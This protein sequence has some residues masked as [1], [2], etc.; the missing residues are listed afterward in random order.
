MSINY[1]INDVNSGKSS[2]YTSNKF[3]TAAQEKEAMTLL[4]SYRNPIKDNGE[5]RYLSRTSYS[6]NLTPAIPSPINMDGELLEGG[7]LTGQDNTPSG[8]GSNNTRNGGFDMSKL[9]KKALLT[10]IKYTAQVVGRRK[11]LT[12]QITTIAEYYKSDPKN[13]SVTINIGFDNASVNA[14]NA[15]KL[16][17]NG[18]PYKS[19]QDLVLAR[20]KVLSL[21]FEAAGI[22]ADKIKWNFVNESKDI[23]FSYDK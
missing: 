7:G 14:Q 3:G 1:T 9:P 12:E 8:D 4:D 20:M 21:A 2:Q 18:G 16:R 17:P 10:F 19:F 13:F 6:E 5:I 23:T 11:E 22:P 15:S